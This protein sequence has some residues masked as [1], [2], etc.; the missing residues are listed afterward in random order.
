MKT[1]LTLYSQ[2]FPPKMLKVSEDF[3][4]YAQNQGLTIC[5]GFVIDFD[6]QNN[7]FKKALFF[8]NKNWIWKENIRPDFIHD[9]SLHYLKEPMFSLKKI[10]EASFPFFNKIELSEIMTNK[11]LTYETFSEFSPKMVL[12]EKPS[13]LEKVNS[14]PTDRII[15][16]PV[17]GSGGMG[18][19]IATKNS[20]GEMPYPFLAQELIETTGYKDWVKGAHDLRV[21]LVN[22]VPFHSF[23]R[24]PPEGEL[25]ANLSRGG[26]IKLIS[27]DDLPQN[28]LDVLTVVSKKLERFDKKMYAIDFIFD[29]SGKPWIIEMNSRPGIALE[30]EELPVRIDYYN[31]LI[32]F[33]LNL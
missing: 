15:L 7:V 16:K 31:H 28:L 26:R 5:R 33:Y 8:E 4:T 30:K 19:R 22:D 27:P 18:I 12:V 17:H 14:L 1:I 21:M 23:L 25:I 29:N 24:I 13:D 32:N 6:S 3:Y 9:R 11:W 20:V 10:I 2:P